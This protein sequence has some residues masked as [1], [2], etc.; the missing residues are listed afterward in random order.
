[1]S[2]ISG[3]KT[4]MLTVTQANV[5]CQEHWEECDVIQTQSYACRNSVELTAS[6]F[7]RDDFVRADP[8]IIDREH[9]SLL[10]AQSH[11]LPLPPQ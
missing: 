1:M 11:F 7:R 6:K 3:K 10:M 2:F 4:F 8:D 5:H 9:H